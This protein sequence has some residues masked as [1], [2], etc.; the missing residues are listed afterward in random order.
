MLDWI[1]L[2]QGMCNS[3]IKFNNEMDKAKE[4]KM[5]ISSANNKHEDDKEMQ[6]V[7]KEIEKYTQLSSNPV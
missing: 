6:I 1:H 3:A 5:F 2:A 4:M 7:K